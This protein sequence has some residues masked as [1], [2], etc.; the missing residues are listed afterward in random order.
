MIAFVGMHEPLPSRGDAP[1]ALLLAVIFFSFGLFGILQPHKLRTA[2]DNFANS[3]K[4]G[5]WHP[6]RMSVP[7]LR[8]VVGGTGIGCAVLF[9]YIAY[10]ALSR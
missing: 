6:Y 10:V 8:L 7:I 3:W 2:I 9:A 4:Q 5:S 1:A